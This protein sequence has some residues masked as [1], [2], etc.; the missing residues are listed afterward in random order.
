LG[1]IEGR[2]FSPAAGSFG[3]IA[4]PVMCAAAF[5]LEIPSSTCQPK[6]DFGRELAIQGAA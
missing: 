2:L 6:N 1:A 5:G 4:E 3:W